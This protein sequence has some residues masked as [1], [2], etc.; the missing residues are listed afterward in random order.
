[1]CFGALFLIAA[2]LMSTGDFDIRSYD[3]RE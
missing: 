3:M 2:A 1:L